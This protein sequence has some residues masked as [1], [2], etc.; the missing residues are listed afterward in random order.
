MLFSYDTCYSVYSNTNYLIR[1][2]LAVII[3]K[4]NHIQDEYDAKV[5]INQS[6]PLGSMLSKL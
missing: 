5:L 2:A 3:S 1:K 4:N 6:I